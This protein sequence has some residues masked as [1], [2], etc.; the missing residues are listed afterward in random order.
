VQPEGYYHASTQLPNG[1]PSIL[2]DVGAWT[3][4]S[5]SNSS[6]R[7][8]ME[9]VAAGHKVEQWKMATPLNI[10]GVGS[11]TQECKWE[12]KIPICV[13]DAGGETATVH[14]FETPTVEGTGEDLPSLLG[15]HSI[16]SK[17]GVLETG[18][19]KERL[20]FPGPGGYQIIWSPGTQH[21]PLKSAPSG[22]LVIPLG[23]FAKVTKKEGGVPQQGTIFH[24]RAQTNSNQ[25][26]PPPPGAASSSQ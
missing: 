8:A 17:E 25:S 24:A 5:G 26:G 11:G 9:A 16:S 3:N 14:H 13:E 7:M 20:S 18:S 19:G 6:R 2:V 22:H 23:D 15:L 21:F 10:A 12:T 1:Q 4:L